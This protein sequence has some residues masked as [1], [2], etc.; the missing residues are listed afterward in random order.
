MYNDNQ[1]IES[2]LY[3]HILKLKSWIEK[4]ELTT[5]RRRNRFVMNIDKK[6]VLPITEDQIIRAHGADP[7]IILTRKPGIYKIAAQ[8]LALGMPLVKPVVISRPYPIKHIVHNGIIL[9][10]EI[11]ISS[12]LVASVLKNAHTIIPFVCSI[13]NGLEKLARQT[14]SEDLVLAMALDA[15]GSAAVEQL[16]MEV[17]RRYELEASERSEFVSQPIGPGLEG[18]SVQE[19]QPLIFKLVDAGSAGIYLSE[20]ML[21]DPI[22]SASFI[23]G[24]SGK[25]FETGSTCEY[26]NLK[27]TCRYKGNHEHA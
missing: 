23:L 17:C 5:V 20:S 4:E 1:L 12:S 26:C 10:D 3:I 22:K 14:S 6:W 9:D 7:E 25:P 19:G 18:W 24:V 2:A 21:M 27:E 8:A 15:L 16:I 13:G 11:R